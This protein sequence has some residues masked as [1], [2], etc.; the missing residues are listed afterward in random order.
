MLCFFMLESRLFSSQVNFM[1]SIVTTVGNFVNVHRWERMTARGWKVR[2]DRLSARLRGGGGCPF[3]QGFAPPC[4]RNA[5]LWEG[6]AVSGLCHPAQ[7]RRGRR[8]RGRE[9]MVGA[10]V[11]GGNEFPSQY[12]EVL[13]TGADDGAWGEVRS[14]VGEGEKPSTNEEPR[15]NEW[16]ARGRKVTSRW[17]RVSVST[18]L[19]PSLRSQRKALGGVWRSTD[20]VTPPK[21][22]G[23]GGLTDGNGWTARGWK[24][25]RSDWLEQLACP[26]GPS[27]SAP[28]GLPR[29]EGVG[30]VSF[31][32]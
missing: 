9:R 2:F 20:S 29:G 28:V 7:I 22:G 8:S 26:L 30:S 32:G 15:I 19:R 24:E 11:E 31:L 18:G 10:R 27:R 16:T 4:G 3:R 17:G 13:R 21:Y 14:G 25:P 6:V 23:A 12:M 5:R 1:V